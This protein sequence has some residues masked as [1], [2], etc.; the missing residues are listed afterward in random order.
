MASKLDLYRIFSV[1]SKVNSFSKAAK[2]LYM[3][4]PAISL[5]IMQ[6]EKELST[7]LFTR[8]PK[9]VNLTSEGELLYEYINSAMNLID[10]GEKKLL[11]SQNLLR[12]ELKV[13][14][15]DTIS[16]YFLLPYLESFHKE[17]PNI[18]LKVIN[19]TTFELCRLLK[20]GEID[21]AFCNLPIN[22]THIEIKSCMEIQDVFV[23][24]E[25]YNNLKGKKISLGE[26]LAYEI[27]L[28]EPNSNSRLYV[29]EFF[30]KHGFKLKAEIE[31]GSHDLLLE[32]AKINLGIACVIK[33]FSKG[34]IE[35]GELHELDLNIRI[36]KREIGI[37]SWKNVS[38]SSAAKT[39]INMF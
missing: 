27:I 31:L 9:G 21:L 1:V 2:E 17:F 4:Q 7:R 38:L 24:G 11:D 25:K 14:A 8:T 3:T 37:C 15:G 18:N 19:R 6:L 23:C 39:F 34:Y 32:F 13:G 26:L 10:S 16:K 20:A 30:Q 28:L 29:D 33:E 5:S 12:G 22:D 36:P 35:S